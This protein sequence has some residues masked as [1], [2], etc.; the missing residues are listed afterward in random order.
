MRKAN[1]IT[2]LV[3]MAG[4]IIALTTSTA[5]MTLHARAGQKAL[6][7]GIG[8]YPHSPK[9][10]LKG[11][12]NDIRM[13][14]EFLT[15]QWGFED[16]DIGILLNDQATK[17]GIMNAI[18]NWLPRVTEPGDRVV[19][20]YSGHGTQVPDKNGDEKDGK[21]EAWVTADLRKG[22]KM[23]ANQMVRDDELAVAFKG[24]ADRE[25]ILIS[26]SC[27][28]GTM[29]RGAPLKD[30]E[31]NNS[32]PKVRFIPFIA[33]DA[34]MG[35]PVMGR[36]EESM[37]R[38]VRSQLT[39]SAAMANQYSW[40]AGGHGLFTKFF[41]DGMTNGAADFN[42]NGIITSAEILNYV[43]PRADEFCQ[44]IEKC[45]NKKFTP[46]IDPRNEAYILAPVG[47]GPIETVSSDDNEDISDI[48]PPL[49]Q[50]ALS[51][52]IRP[53]THHKLGDEV[54]FE[55]TTEFDGYLTLMDLNA[56][57]E[58]VLLFPTKEDLNHGKTGKIRAASKLRVP[59]ASYGFSF[60]AG[61]P[62]GKGQLLAIV[63]Q[64]KID[65]SDLLEGNRDFEPIK[66]K[67]K[68]AKKISEKLYSVWTGEPDFN[69]SVRWAVGYKDY[70]ISQ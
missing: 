24:L 14:D 10:N 47:S 63:T 45:R 17:K 3:K 54:S 31:E 68:L 5:L 2:K 7:I 22:G 64:D 53:D 32:D 34:H 42:K 27:H 56:A 41:V 65:F 26:D 29:S 37:S 59:D 61:L 44:H 33:D 51:I 62:T 11:P 70:S 50:N 49:K 9:S 66:D 40:E 4:L 13:M 18:T 8:E 38:E 16:R 28:S 55:I 46:N 21:D 25:L 43:R 69:R 48:L 23:R 39:I 35:M 19:I 6:L 58:M 12:P 67:S 52:A 60:E 30:E 15:N 36:D 20:Y 1:I 57:N